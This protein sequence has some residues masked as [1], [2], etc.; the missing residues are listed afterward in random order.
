MSSV[1][2]NASCTTITPGQGPGRSLT[3]TGSARYAGRVASS[4]AVPAPAAVSVMVIIGMASKYARGRIP[5]ARMRRMAAATDLDLTGMARRLTTA[6]GVVGVV[7]G[8]SRARGDHTAES[9]VDLG[10]YYRP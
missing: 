6:G 3:G 7:L 9:D 4:G 5:S 1:M 8:G 2:P 10:L